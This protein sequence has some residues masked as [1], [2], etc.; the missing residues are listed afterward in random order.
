M[1]EVLGLVYK[2]QRQTILKRTVL[3][4]NEGKPEVFTWTQSGNF[5]LNMLLCLNT[6]FKMNMCVMSMGHCKT[7]FKMFAILCKIFW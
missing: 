4:C 7:S 2:L 1:E 6:H 3:T 5:W